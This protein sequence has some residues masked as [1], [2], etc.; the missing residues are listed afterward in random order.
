MVAFRTSRTTPASD[1]GGEARMMRTARGRRRRWRIGLPRSHLFRSFAAQFAVL[2]LIFLTVP[3]ILYFQFRSLDADKNR[4]IRDSAEKQG[5]LIASGLT[6][7]LD[8]FDGRSYEALSQELS[9]LT[10]GSVSAKLLY[11]PVG[12][13]G[14]EQFFYVASAPISPSEYLEAELKQLAGAGVIQTLR[15]T[16][17]GRRPPPKRF[18]NPA[19]TQEVLTSFTPVNSVKGCW[20]L[21]TSHATKSIL[22]SSVGQPYWRT[23][24][25]QIAAAIY[26]LMVFLVLYLFREVWRGLRQF[27]RLARDIRNDDASGA[28]FAEMNQLPDLKD[29]AMEFDR[30][31]HALRSSA[32]LLRR[33]AD[34]NAHAFKTPIAVIAHSL[35]RI[36]RGLPEEDV[37]GL[38]A[39]EL[40]EQAV[41]RL[42]SLVSASRRLDEAAAET[43]DPPREPVD[44]SAMLGRMVEAYSEVQ[45]DG[46]I[47][48]TENI[49]PGVV[50]LAGDDMIETVIENMLDN[51]VSFS[52]PGAELQVELR[53]N[54]RW[55]DLSVSDE[56]PGVD[57]DNIDRIFDRYFTVRPPREP[58][59]GENAL[60]AV[61]SHS[62]IGLW[63]VRRNVEAINGT[64]MAENRSSGGLRM[65]VRLPLLAR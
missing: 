12:V 35:A 55:A 21:L 51:A 16:C 47:R 2:I 64:V 46:V 33:A 15:I 56:G 7:Q 14:P 25:V 24:Q 49:D 31:V 13:G 58:W 5:R 29:V 53:K 54:G 37:K 44:I 59:N 41:E 30:M 9:R 61:E 18:I 20:V 57:T 23:P 10:D 43:L 52:P 38:R 32:D 34:D 4:L 39:A 36:R 62:G 60:P 17:D 22:S 6:P 40:I 48:F 65:T 8:A 63:I 26:M 45:P 28:S 27:E 50:V 3:G 42:D 11:R 19:G 1:I